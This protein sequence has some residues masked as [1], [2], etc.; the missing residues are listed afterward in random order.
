MP[1]SSCRP[2][3][4]AGV[5]PLAGLEQ[6]PQRRQVVA[7][8]VGGVG[9][10]LLDGAHRGRRGEQGLHAVLGGHPPERARIGRADRLALVEH[11]GRAEQQ[12]PVDDVGVPHHPA[13]IRSGPEHFAGMRV[14]DVRAWSTAARRR[15]RRCRGRCPWACR[16]CPRCTAR[17]ADR[18]RRPGRGRRVPRRPSPRPS[19]RR[20]RAIRSQ[21][22]CSRCTITQGGVGCSA[23]SDAPRRAS[24]C[25]RRCGS[26]RCRTTPRRR[27]PGAR[28]RCA[29]RARGRAK[30]P[31]TTECTAPSRAQASIAMTASGT[32]GM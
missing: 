17:R 28:R 31:N 32:I 29:P 9:V 5:Q 2:V 13:D 27:P 10:V 16:W 24:A 12:R 20:G 25:S 7:G 3:V 15:A 8:Q 23:R 26:A 21:G 6:V 22:S 30:P 4:G 11:G 19:R 14:V 1:S 18:S